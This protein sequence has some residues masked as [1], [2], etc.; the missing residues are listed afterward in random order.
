MTVATLA[1]AA[2]GLAGGGYPG[3][4][5]LTLLLLTAA[6]VGAIASLLPVPAGMSGRAALLGTLAAGQ[7]TGH[8][9]MTVANAPGSMSMM[10]ESSSGAHI[11][12]HFP[13]M[14]GL[15]SGPMVLAHTAATLLCAVLITATER[16]YTL[17]SQTVRTLTAHPRPLVP[18]GPARWSG[19]PRRPYRF[20]RTAGLGSRAPPAPA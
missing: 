14:L 16:L 9:A 2:H 18:P 13:A 20:L 8:L 12:G 6:G 11:F 3:S 7:M 15:S 19:S 17:A 4:A 10:H 1:A 5:A